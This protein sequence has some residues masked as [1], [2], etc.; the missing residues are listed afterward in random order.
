MEFSTLSQIDAVKKM[1]DSLKYNEIKKFKRI[2][3]EKYKTNETSNNTQDAFLD[4]SLRHVFED[5]I[6][7]WNK[8]IIDIL[9]PDLYKGVEESNKDWWE[10][11]Y[12]KIIRVFLLFWKKDRIIYVGVGFL[13]ASVFVFFILVTN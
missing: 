2:P 8:I 13:I 4:M 9:S 5:F 7:V 10:I 6:L 11:L 3:I 1:E 12:E